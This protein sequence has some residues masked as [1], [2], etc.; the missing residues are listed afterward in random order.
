VRS[1]DPPR[2]PQLY[3]KPEDR[4][5]VNNVVQHNA[6]LAEEMEGKLRERMKG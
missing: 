3:F 1:E 4:F 6:E 2:G 5:E